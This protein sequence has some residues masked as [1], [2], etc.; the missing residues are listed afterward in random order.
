MEP[1]GRD[2]HLYGK[3]SDSTIWQLWLDASK[4]LTSPQVETGKVLVFYSTPD[5]TDLDQTSE[6][7]TGCHLLSSRRLFEVKDVMISYS[8]YSSHTSHYSLRIPPPRSKCARQ[9][10]YVRMDAPSPIMDGWLKWVLSWYDWTMQN[11]LFRYK[12]QLLA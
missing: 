9:I 6:L 4:P 11:K 7:Q 8:R 2:S 3:P 5:Q 12:Y 1:R 10:A